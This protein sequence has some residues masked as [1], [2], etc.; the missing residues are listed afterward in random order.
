MGN[1]KL[2]GDG[3]ERYLYFSVYKS[4]RYLD[5]CN[6]LNITSYLEKKEMFK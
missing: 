1:W 2:S 5:L 3:E 4:C 6:I